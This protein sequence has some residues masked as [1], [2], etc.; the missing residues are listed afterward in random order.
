MK[1]TNLWATALFVA[2]LALPLV[3]IAD[4][5]PMMGGGM[6]GQGAMSGMYPQMM[7]QRKEMMNSMMGMM[8][9][10]MGILKNLNHSPSADQKKKL[11]EMMSKL[12]D[13][14]KKHDAMHEEMMKKMKEKREYKSK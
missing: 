14:M 5:K 7:E 8:K 11:D 1:K 10:T 3:A 2:I 9:E 13:M 12:D 6:M 4:E